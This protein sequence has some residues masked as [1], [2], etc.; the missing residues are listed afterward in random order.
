MS[1]PVLVAV[2]ALIV[3]ID[4][5]IKARRYRSESVEIAIEFSRRTKTLGGIIGGA[6]YL[7]GVGAIH[8]HQSLTPIMISVGVILLTAWG[9][10]LS[11]VFNKRV[12]LIGRRVIDI[13]FIGRRREL[14]VSAPV[15]FDSVWHGEFLHLRAADIYLPGPW[16]DIGTKA[17]YET[18]ERF[19][20]QVI[21]RAASGGNSDHA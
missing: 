20:A 17:A 1:L 3:V 13:S 19:K 8:H 11:F 7:V 5:A 14:P 12:E 21:A 10:G 16:M 4:A 2:L 9:T 15:R 18:L 6:L